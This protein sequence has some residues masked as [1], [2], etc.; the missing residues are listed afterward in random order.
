MIL[1]K[2]RLI[3]FNNKFS[4]ELHFG[5]KFIF[6]LHLTRFYSEKK[7]NIITNALKCKRDIEIKIHESFSLLFFIIILVSNYFL[8]NLKNKLMS[9]INKKT[10]NLFQ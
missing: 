4:I 8:L 7:I 3:V 9:I 5:V 2:T 10:I 6:M 1:L